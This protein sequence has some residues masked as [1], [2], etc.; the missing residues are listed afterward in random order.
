MP[1]YMEFTSILLHFKLDKIIYDKKGDAVAAVP[2]HKAQ[3]VREFS[4]GLRDWQLW[5][6][7]KHIGTEAEAVDFSILYLNFLLT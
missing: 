2:N 1:T 3:I 7:Y 4:Y 5:F 6:R